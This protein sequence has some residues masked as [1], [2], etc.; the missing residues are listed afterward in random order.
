MLDT[1][2]DTNTALKL[3]A[4]AALLL[5]AARSRAWGGGCMRARADKPCRE[6]SARERRPRKRLAASRGGRWQPVSSEA[7]P[8][9]REEKTEAQRERRTKPEVHRG[10]VNRGESDLD[11]GHEWL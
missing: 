8:T 2:L 10:H 6:V 5:A 9:R 7:E 3:V 4:G 1:S 11:E